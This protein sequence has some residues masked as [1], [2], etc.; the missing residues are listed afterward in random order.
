MSKTEVP[1]LD[2]VRAAAERTRKHLHHTPLVYSHTFSDWLGYQVY[3][4]CEN[5]Q[6][7]GSFKPRGGLNRIS[8]LSSEERSRGVITIS[9]GNHAQGVAYA[10]AK[11]QV[12]AVIVMPEDAVPSK[13]LQESRGLTLVHPFDD[14]MLVAG[15]GTVGWEIYQDLPRVDAVVCGVGGGG[16]IAGIATAMRELAP[17]AHIYGVEP[18]GAATMSEALAAGAVIRLETLDTIADGLAPPF[19]GE[20]NLAVVESSVDAVVRVTDTA[21][22]KA[23]RLILERTKMLAEPAG[24]AALAALLEGQLSIDPGAVVAIVISGGNVALDRLPELITAPAR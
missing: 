12:P 24:A 8:T 5:L 17:E 9:A 6:K 10:A 7:T 20:L 16:L 1:Q 19:V 3:L 15:H 21:I 4:K 22:R 11:L 2:D 13:E 23:M 14:A 18:E